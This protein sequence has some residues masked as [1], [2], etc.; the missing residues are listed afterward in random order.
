MKNAVDV[1]DQQPLQHASAERY[2]RAMYWAR[3]CVHGRTRELR[4]HSVQRHANGPQKH[5][6]ATVALNEVQ[7]FT[8]DALPTQRAHCTSVRTHPPLGPAS[9]HTGPPRARDREPPRRPRAPRGRGVHSARRA[10]RPDGPAGR[11]PQGGH[12]EPRRGRAGIDAT[13]P[14]PCAVRQPRRRARALRRLRCEDTRGRD[15][16][17]SKCNS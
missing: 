2:A 16:F 5:T 12:M 11:R 14:R 8:E 10:G 7:A 17:C 13:W 6:T 4:G 3:M 15:P 9:T 1:H